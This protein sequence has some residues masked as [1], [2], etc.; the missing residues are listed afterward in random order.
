MIAILKACYNK[1][2]AVKPFT[3]R[4]SNSE[5]YF[6]CMDFKFT[7]KDKEYKKIIDKLDEIL[8]QSH[9]TKK[10]NLNDIF[11]EFK[12]DYDPGFLKNIIKLNLDI[13]NTNFK[14]INEIKKFIDD[15]NFYGDTYQMKR[16]E[17]INAS[18]YWISHFFPDPKKFDEAKKT[19]KKMFQ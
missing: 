17:Q 16:Q 1:V 10:L 12:P 5:K 11:P 14:C 8:K 6:V 7:D 15:Q 4:P 2:I 9:Q 18:K 3:S 19:L 13:E